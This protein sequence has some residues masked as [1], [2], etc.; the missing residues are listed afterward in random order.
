MKV[1]DL[2]T[3]TEESTKY[4]TQKPAVVGKDIEKYYT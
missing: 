2:Q 3:R 1:T 4:M